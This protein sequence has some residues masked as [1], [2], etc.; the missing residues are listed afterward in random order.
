MTPQ[1]HDECRIFFAVVI[2]KH[3]SFLSFMGSYHR[4]V[5]SSNNAVPSLAVAKK[6]ARRFAPVQVVQIVQPV[7]I[8][9]NGAALRGG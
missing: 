7:Q 9:L 6:A 1:R 2:F 5:P 8:V 3:I 4:R